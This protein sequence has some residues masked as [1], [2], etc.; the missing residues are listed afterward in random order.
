MKFPCKCILTLRKID[1]IK[2]VFSR[3]LC[4]VSEQTPEVALDE[5]LAIIP[6]AKQ[7]VL[8]FTQGTGYTAPI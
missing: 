6:Q 1:N 8:T 4:G 2:A 7:S 5:S 3:G